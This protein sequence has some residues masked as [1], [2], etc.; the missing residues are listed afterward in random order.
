MKTT[1]TI[2]ALVAFFL[3][4]S[5]EDKKQAQDTTVIADTTKIDADGNEKPFSKFRKALAALPGKDRI[6]VFNALNNEMKADLWKDRI[7]EAIPA[8]KE[9][10]QEVMRQLLE[11]IT[12]AIY[13]DS[14]KAFEK[15]LAAWEKSA[16]TAF[17]NDSFKLYGIIVMLDERAENANGGKLKEDEKETCDCS[18]PFDFCWRRGQNLVCANPQCNFTRWGCGPLWLFICDALCVKKANPGN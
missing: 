16:L 14:A 5:C 17:E 9:A 15:E 2:F 7:E 13:T 18:I 11:Q 1:L 6:N 4:S 12:P 3:V 10:E 8:L